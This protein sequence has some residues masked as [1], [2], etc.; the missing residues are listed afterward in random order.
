MRFLLSKKNSRE[1]TYSLFGGL[2]YFETKLVDSEK[3]VLTM[4]SMYTIRRDGG[5]TFDFHYHVYSNDRDNYIVRKV[6]TP[7]TL[8]PCFPSILIQMQ[9]THFYQCKLGLK[10]KICAII[11]VA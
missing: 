9:E 5:F 11:K 10:V 2:V 6:K 7:V 3:A 4:I 1:K 8:F